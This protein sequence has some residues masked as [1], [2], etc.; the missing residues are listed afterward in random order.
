MTDW[1]IGRDRSIGLRRWA[2]LR[3]GRLEA[4]RS[5]LVPTLAPKDDLLG[6]ALG[7]LG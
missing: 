3:W 7:G 1:P 2:R 6:A 4:P 5:H